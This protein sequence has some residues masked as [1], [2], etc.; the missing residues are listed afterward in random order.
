MAEVGNHLGKIG[1]HLNPEVETNIMPI[2]DID[3]LTNEQKI[4][5]FTYVTEEKGITYEQLG[6][7]KA[8][9]WRYKK[10]LREIPK[11]IM[12]KALQFLAP[13]EIARVVYGKKI[14]KADINDLLKVINTAVEDLQFRSLLFMML[15]RFLGEYVKQNTNSYAVTE[16][17]LKLFEKILEQKSKA[18]KEERLRHIKY[19][20]KDLGFSLSPESLKEYIV[21]LAAEEGPN[22]ARHRAN[23]LKLFIKEVVMSRNPILGQILYNSFKVP[24]VD[25]KYSP[26]PISLD[27]LKK[28]FQ[29]IDHLGAKTF[30]LILAETGLRVGE[31]Y[32]L[33]LEQVDLENGI[34]KLMKSSATKRA[35]I[36]FLHKETI[37]WIKKNY[38]PF[39]EDFISKYEKAVQQIGGDVEKWRMKFFPFQLADLRAEV[40]EGM[41]KVGKEFRLYDLRSFFASYM[42]KSGVSPFIINV[43]QGRMAPGQFKILQQH[44]FVISDIELK[45]IYE[46]KAPKLLS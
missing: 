4:R 5:L 38:L 36:S 42:A 7:S 28:I 14:E 22:V 43:L 31:V 19:A 13:D 45:K 6:I 3:K 44:Y 21:E 15:N 12:E 11:E 39:R 20:M 33:T 17:D 26:P 46:E 41:R 10:G 40:K 34:I 25:Y 30:F 23:T 35:Y 9:G 27:L 18:T 24:K 8:T 37:E 1:N 32:S 16:E 29:S 2:L